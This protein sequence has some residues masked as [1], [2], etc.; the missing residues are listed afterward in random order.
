MHWSSL[1]SGGYVAEYEH[2]TDEFTLERGCAT[3]LVEFREWLYGFVSEEGRRE[4]EKH[5][6]TPDET[7]AW[8]SRQ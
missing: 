2:A 3:G 1:A 7:R 8:L 6:Y 5:Y 4:K